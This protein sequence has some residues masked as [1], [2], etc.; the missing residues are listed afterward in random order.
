M[1]EVPTLDLGPLDVGRRD[2]VHREAL[3][4][5]DGVYRYRLHRTWSS[6]D[7]DGSERR[8]TFVML[9]PSVGNQ[10][11]DDNTLTRCR[12]FATAWGYDGYDVVNLF[13]FITPYP[14]DMFAAARAGVDIIGP[15]NNEHLRRAAAYAKSRREPIIAAWGAGA[16][17]D[18]VREVAA[19][20]HMD[21]LRCLGTTASGMP[22][23]PLYLRADTPLSPWK[24]PAA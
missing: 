8:V 12:G 24:A 5:D 13:A 20:P 4:S 3:L 6:S 2:G 17:L 21:E 19:L 23:H 1:T 16:P 18:R 11:D 9:N 10:V 14:A 7:P 22:K 15:D